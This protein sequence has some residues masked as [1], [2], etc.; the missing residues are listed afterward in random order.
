MR[1]NVFPS[2]SSTV[3]LR[4]PPTAS[5]RAGLMPRLPSSAKAASR[6]VIERATK[7][8]PARVMSTEEVPAGGQ[9]P[10]GYA[11]EGDLDVHDQDVSEP[12][13]SGASQP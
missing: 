12:Q 11:C 10:D 3:A 7:P 6:S 8:F 2:E 1:A 4:P 9:I 13:S 5:L